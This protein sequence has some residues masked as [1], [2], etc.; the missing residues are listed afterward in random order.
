MINV[1]C[2]S[3]HPHV[4]KFGDIECCAGKETRASDFKG[5]SRCETVVYASYV[6]GPKGIAREEPEINLTAKKFIR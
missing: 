4:S 2:N 1:T 3:D 6:R 5:F